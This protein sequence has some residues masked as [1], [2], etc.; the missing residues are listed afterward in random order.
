REGT[1]LETGLIGKRFGAVQAVSAYGREESRTRQP[2]TLGTRRRCTARKN[3]LRTEWIGRINS[4]LVNIGVG[5]GLIF[6]A[7]TMRAGTFT[8]GDFALY[9]QLLPR[10]TN[11]LTFAGDMLAQHRRAGVSIERLEE[12]MQDAPTGAIVRH[13]PLH[14]TG[15]TPPLKP[16]TPDY[17]PLQLLEVKGLTYR[18]PGS[19]T[20]IED[21]SFTVRKGEFVVITGRIG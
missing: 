1:A 21:I 3:T 11:S 17:R 18:F 6:S 13:R 19:E 20:G 14:L 9:E 7:A 15:E 16:T 4:R 8:V 2:N 10:L 5:A 12:L